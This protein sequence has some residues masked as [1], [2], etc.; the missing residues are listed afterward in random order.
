[1]QRSFVRGK[2]CGCWSS[3]TL[4]KKE[5]KWRY[6]YLSSRNWINKLV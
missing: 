2:L 3:E 5:R 4:R 1:M 6:K